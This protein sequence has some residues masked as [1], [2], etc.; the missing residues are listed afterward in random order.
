[1]EQ[2]RKKLPAPFLARMQRLLGEQY[3]AFLS[4]YLCER[5]YGLRV[6]TLKLTPQAFFILPKTGFHL[7]S[8]PWIQEGFY[9]L[10]EDAPGRHPYYYAGLYY[11][12]EPSA[13]TSAALLDVA[14]GRRVL[15][16]CA[17][18]GG[19]S[20][21]L[22]A[23][24]GG[25]GILTA[26]DISAPRCKALL[27][28]L[29]VSGVEN[30]VV[31]NC[32][33]D[34]LAWRFPQYYDRI[35]VD[36]PCSGEGMFRKEEALIRAWSEEKTHACAKTQREILLQAAD[37]LAPGGRLLYSTC[38][39]SPSE[40]EASV[41]FLL[42]RREEMH[43][44]DC[45]HVEGAAPGLSADVCL[46]ELTDEEKVEN[47]D[48]Y[49]LEKCL[50]LWPHLMGG[51]GHFIALFEKEKAV[52]RLPQTA[53]AGG[54]KKGAKS[55]GR[56]SDTER[57]E[58]EAALCFLKEA[59]FF[60]A[61]RHEEQD[62]S[63]RIVSDRG[64]ISIPCLKESDLAG[65]TCLRNGLFVGEVRKGRFIPSQS[66][67]LV[68][69]AGKCPVSFILEADDERIVRYLKGETI[70]LREQEAEQFAD[71]QCGGY[72][73]VCVDGWPV[74]WARQTGMLLKNKY[75]QGWRMTT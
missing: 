14:G 35:L 30:A 18:P 36:A 71:G 21:M 5:K 4:A 17:A 57:E 50:R 20:T 6:N 1:M 40:N 43:L 41:A 72:R 9:Y 19:K 61:G 66:L 8:I 48:R 53:G 63:S 58:K 69:D 29:E 59:G 27:K 2:T 42:S 24:M 38:T 26:N 25:S 49:P 54:G 39:F 33:P 44:I 62:I 16:L 7:S 47:M 37:M 31:T 70:I 75:H 65:L 60:E 45:P 55:K 11:L 68:M 32:R 64:R 73:L 15:D 56:I 3:E 10:Q 46:P 74:G 28:N 22:A 67:A 51:E 23:K 52:S 13:M 34:Q 12:Q